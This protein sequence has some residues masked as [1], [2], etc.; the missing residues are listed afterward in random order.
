[1][2]LQNATSQHDKVGFYPDEVIWISSLRTKQ[3][4]TSELTKNEERPIQMENHSG[5]LADGYWQARK[6][7]EPIIRAE[8]EREFSDRLRIATAADQRHIRKEIEIEIA[9]R[10]DKLAPPEALY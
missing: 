3:Q 5:F 9:K 8:V 1:M 2:I 10:L 4:K 7:S 6:G